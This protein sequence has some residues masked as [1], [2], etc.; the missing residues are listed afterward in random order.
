[1]C[2]EQ[3]T[4]NLCF[5]DIFPPHM[6]SGESLSARL[7]LQFSSS[8]ALRDFETS[9][10]PWGALDIMQKKWNWKLNMSLGK[11]F[12]ADAFITLLF[13]HLSKNK[14]KAFI[15]SNKLPCILSL[16]ESLSVS[17]T[18]IFPIF[19]HFFFLFLLFCPPP[20]PSP[21]LYLLKAVTQ[22]YFGISNMMAS[23]IN[24]LNQRLEGCDKGALLRWRDAD[25]SQGLSWWRGFSDSPASRRALWK[26]TLLLKL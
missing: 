17:R 25:I 6:Y 3:N 23:Q 12:H 2:E 19:Q 22:K 9:Q 24:N 20:P 1:M 18:L 14:L 8:I 11:C 21:L 7:Q 13:C 10:K 4:H 26:S 5:M 15:Y 16:W